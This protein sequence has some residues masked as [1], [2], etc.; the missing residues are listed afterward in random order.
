MVNL[1]DRGEVDFAPPRVT[2]CSMRRILSRTSD[3]GASRRAVAIEQRRHARG[4][5]STVATVT[6]VTI[7]PA[8]VCEKTGRNFVRTAICRSRSRALPRL[9]A[10]S[11][12]R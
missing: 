6:E 1:G 4:G 9:S 3:L 2:R 11:R 7:S 10:S 12:R 5:K 8:P